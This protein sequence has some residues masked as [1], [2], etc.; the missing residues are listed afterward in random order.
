MRLWS[1]HNISFFLVF[2]YVFS[3]WVWSLLIFLDYGKVRLVVMGKVFL[4]AIGSQGS[5]P[6][7]QIAPGEI[8]RCAT[9]LEL[10]RGFSSD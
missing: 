6:C 4:R 3:Q 7:E 9:L 5:S 2:I 8:V 10:K 1:Q